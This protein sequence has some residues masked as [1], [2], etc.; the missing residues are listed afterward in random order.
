MGAAN[1]SLTANEGNGPPRSSGAWVKY[2][3]ANVTAYFFTQE[4]M[5]TFR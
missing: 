2:T 3:V 4:H 1:F 5:H